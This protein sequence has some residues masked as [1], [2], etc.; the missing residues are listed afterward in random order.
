MNEPVAKPRDRV[1]Y[2][3]ATGHDFH[4]R[5]LSI[6]RES[7]A[8]IMLD[9]GRLIENVEFSDPAI[10]GMMFLHSWRPLASKAAITPETEGMWTE[11]MAAGIVTTLLELEAGNIPLDQNLA[12]SLLQAFRRGVELVLEFEREG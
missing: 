3:D 8:K 1:V 6:D 11:A 9:E 5:I 2:R 10:S 7:E 4:G 12:R